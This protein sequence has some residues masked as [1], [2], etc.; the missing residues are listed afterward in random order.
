MIYMKNMTPENIAK[1]CG[2]T[3]TGSDDIKDICVTAVTTDS[4]KVDKGCL[5]I[6]IKG[7]RVDAHKFIP[8]VLE[9]GALVTLTE[10]EEYAEKYPCILVKSTTEAIKDIA[11]EY[12]AGL[13]TKVVSITGSVGK[14]STKEIIYSV[15]S[16]KFRTRKT[17]GN[18]NNALGL[19]LTIF[20]L[21]ENDE[22]AVLEMGINHFGEMHIL[23]SIAPPDVSVITNI[24]ECHLEFLGDRNGVL[25]AKTEVFDHLKEGGLTVLNGDDDKLASVN[26]V[27]GNKPVFYGINSGRDI[28]ADEIESEGMDAVTCR[29]HLQDKS[30]KVRIPK[31]GKHMVLNALAATAVGNI[32]GMTLEEIKDGI[33]S[34]E[35]I[36]GRFNV[37]EHDGIKIIDDCYNANPMSMKA[38]L[39]ILAAGE[40]RRVA[41]LGDMG[42]LGAG[43]ENYHKEVG[44]FAAGLAI[45]VLAIAGKKAKDIAQGA[46]EAESEKCHYISNVSSAGQGEK[47]TKPVPAAAERESAKLDIATAE[48]KSKNLTIYEFE[49]TDELI[50]HL[51]KIIKKGDTVLVKASH[52]MCFDKVVGALSTLS[53]DE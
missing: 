28:Y 50:S 2:G 53:P 38:S 40:G 44:A 29:I 8:Q 47:S 5:F 16:K 41:L 43:S 4:R 9:E 20:T 19:P 52:S 35:G 18:L 15:L 3:F 13:N 1:W 36:S 11:R 24:G 12:L 30:I 25:K 49:T 23:A 17:Q 48:R 22:I 33:E 21:D 10:E 45:D 46:R 39:G 14:T 26:E 31:P 6:P 51:Q 27:G 37:I 7:A 34:L 42:E 32:F